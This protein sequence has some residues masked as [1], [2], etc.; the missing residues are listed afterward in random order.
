MI[1]TFYRVVRFGTRP[2]PVQAIEI[3]SRTIGVGSE[4]FDKNTANVRYLED[5]SYAW[6]QLVEW[7]V[8]N[9]NRAKRNVEKAQSQMLKIERNMEGQNESES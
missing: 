6:K 7:A 4:S 9:E 5:E 8:Q 3:N 2:V 1:K